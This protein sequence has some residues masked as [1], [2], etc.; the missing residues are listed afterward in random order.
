M[1]PRR[2]AIFVPNLRGGGTERVM[3]TL[4]REFS[5]QGHKVDLLLA[6]G[7]G[8]YRATIPAE[9]RIVDFGRNGVFGSLGDL[10]RYLRRERPDALYSAL[11]HANVVA[12]LANL[13]AGSPTRNVVSERTSFREAK[14]H[15]RSLNERLVRLLMRVTYR[16]AYRIAVVAEAIVDELH[17]DLGL[18]RS[19][20]VAIRNPI[21]DQGLLDAAAQDPEEPIFAQ[22]RPVILAAGRLAFEKDFDSLIRAFALT[23][24]RHDAALVIVGE[25]PDRPRLEALVRQLGLESHV[26]L[27]GFVDNPFA[28]MRAA[29]LF[30][31]SSRFEGMP[32]VI[33]QA[34]ACGTPV[35]S[36][37]CRTGPREILE[38]GRWGKLVPV[39]DIPALADAMI[40]ALGEKEH[41]DVRR[42]VEDFSVSVAVQRY[43]DLALG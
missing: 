10:V 4:A 3:A 35:V 15:L 20:I 25:G 14:R 26:A 11:S 29:G 43:L 38:G 5:Q 27:P 13:L 42:A 7:E 19:R 32:G 40:S 8:P 39:G 21:V 16:R 36:T 18:D 31:L 41:P 17:E 34:M 30:V 33:V 1:R 12:L 6:Q 9:V 28:F 22:G 23:R 37:D 2:L 24:L